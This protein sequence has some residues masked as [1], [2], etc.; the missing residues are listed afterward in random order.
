[1]EATASKVIESKESVRPLNIINTDFEF[2]NV[3]KEKKVKGKIIFYIS[4]FPCAKKN[5]FA[6]TMF[7][8]IDIYEIKDEDD[9]INLCR[10]IQLEDKDE[11]FFLEWNYMENIETGSKEF[12]L[13]TGGQHGNLYKISFDDPDDEDIIIGC[14]HTPIYE[15]K[16]HPKDRN[17]C[18]IAA[19]D[20][21]IYL[22]N[23]KQKICFTVADSFTAIKSLTTTKVSL[24]FNPSGTM[25]V[26]GGNDKELS[27]WKIDLEALQQKYDKSNLIETA[28]TNRA[29]ITIEAFVRIYD[30]VSHDVDS[31][32]WF[33]DDFM[34]IKS[35]SGSIKL[36]KVENIPKISVNFYCSR[37]IL[38][39][40]CTYRYIKI[41]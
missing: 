9:T 37:K 40:L 38:V 27:F 18:A 32:V 24:S 20:G 35:T 7:D 39:P 11:A 22:W 31:I 15:I 13:L 6:A 14:I 23:L 17:V 33:H 30:L 34:I 16:V 25:M 2:R 8:K 29:S 19:E 5:V 10:E 36:W 28:S 4:F 12:M 26:S 41:H 21:L 1:M 3:V